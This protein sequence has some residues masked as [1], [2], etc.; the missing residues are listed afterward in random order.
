MYPLDIAGITGDGK[1]MGEGTAFSRIVYDFVFNNDANE[2]TVTRLLSGIPPDTTFTFYEGDYPS[3]S[4]PGAIVDI[5]H[6]RD[7]YM[8]ER[9]NHGWTNRYKPIS[10]EDLVSCLLKSTK[11]NMGADSISVM[12]LYPHPPSPPEAKTWLPKA[13]KWWQFWK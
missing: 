3:P 6:V 12:H 2:Q 13:K 8:I 4:D 7:K 11:Y 9:S 5:Q 10:F 1:L